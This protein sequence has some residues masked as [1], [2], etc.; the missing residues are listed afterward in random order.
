MHIKSLG[1][2]ELFAADRGLPR[3]IAEEPNETLPTRLLTSRVG[4]L[5]A[6]KAAL[7]KSSQGLLSPTLVAKAKADKLV[8]R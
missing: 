6:C 5:Q 2:S 8:S 3:H 1:P 4:S 7:L